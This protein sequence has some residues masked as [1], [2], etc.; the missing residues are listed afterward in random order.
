MKIIFLVG[1][2]VEIDI[3]FVISYFR[4][5]FISYCSVPQQ[6]PC[7]FVAFLLLNYLQGSG[8]TANI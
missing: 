4:P 2:D 1:L 7:I 8:P 6:C 3:A 5:V